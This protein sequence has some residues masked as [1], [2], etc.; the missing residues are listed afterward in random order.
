MLVDYA[1]NDDNY[2][3][4]CGDGGNITEQS[5]KQS[6]VRLREHLKTILD[7]KGLKVRL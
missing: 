7:C 1:R 2:D 5:V 6:V 4:V 3:H